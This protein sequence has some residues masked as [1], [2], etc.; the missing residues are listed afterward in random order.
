MHESIIVVFNLSVSLCQKKPVFYK[1][2][3]K[4]Y[5]IFWYSVER[6]IERNYWTT[7]INCK[8]ELLYK[9]Y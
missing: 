2:W 1:C 3:E 9:F 5:C 4:T 8:K 7:L 6:L